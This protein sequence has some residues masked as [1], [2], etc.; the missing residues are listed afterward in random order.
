MTVGIENEP[1]DVAS[2]QGKSNKYIPNLAQF[3]FRPTYD[4]ATDEARLLFDKMESISNDFK[5]DTVYYEE[6]IDGMKKLSP[7]CIN[8]VIADP[9]FGISFTGKSG[10]YNR[11]ENLVIEGYKEAKGSYEQFTEDWIAQ[12][13]RILKD[14]GSICVFSGWTNLEAVLRGARKADLTTLNH[15]VWHYPFGVYTKKRFVTSHYHLLLLVKDSKDYF[16]NKLEH[17]PED[18]WSIKRQYQAGELKNGTK[19][20]LEVVTRCIDFSSRPGD[21]VLDPFMGNGTTAV[22]AKRNWRHFLGFE[23]NKQM[24]PII[25]RETKKARLG[26]SYTPYSDRL[27]T[28]ED[29]GRMYPRAYR[30]Y[31]KRE[32]PGR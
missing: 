31:L 16:F 15:I 22:A 1:D 28:I 13:P 30:E 26:E 18:V 17:Y 8:L 14:D 9:P 5:L 20:P 19:L 11:D 2:G 12:V 6:C 27:P 23:I 3:Y 10:A 29:L 25:D 7:K 4:W 24:R 32:D 21:I